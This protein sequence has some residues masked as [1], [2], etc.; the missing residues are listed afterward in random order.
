MNINLRSRKMDE[1][2]GFC[3]SM[4]DIPVFEPFKL[5]IEVHSCE[6]NRSNIPNH[7]TIDIS[8]GFLGDAFTKGMSLQ[9]GEMNNCSVNFGSEVWE[10][11]STDDCIVDTTLYILN[12][13]VVD[14]LDVNFYIK[15]H[16]N[17]TNFNCESRMVSI[18]DIVNVI[19]IVDICK[20]DSCKYEYLLIGNFLWKNG[21]LFYSEKS[22]EK[23]AKLVCEDLANKKSFSLGM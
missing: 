16:T 12:R 19:S 5:V 3:N 2:I 13:D 7:A 9:P 6:N 10:K 17:Y 18:S 1:R 20:N 15:G 14:Q 23:L 8:A 11:V 22:A 21:M 4:R